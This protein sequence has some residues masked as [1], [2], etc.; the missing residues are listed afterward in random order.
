VIRMTRKRVVKH[1]GPCAVEMSSEATGR[2]SKQVSAS[3][4][5]HQRFIFSTLM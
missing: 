2:A 1:A 4:G 3:W 5:D